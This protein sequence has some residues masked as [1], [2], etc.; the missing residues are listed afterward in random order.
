MHMATNY[1]NALG[2]SVA[3]LHERRRSGTETEITH[4]ID[5]VRDRACL[6]IDDM[7]ARAVRSGWLAG[8]PLRP[9]L[10]R[11]RAADLT[12]TPTRRVSIGSRSHRHV[13][14]TL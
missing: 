7:I 11:P 3:V 6:I 14:C 2:A 4:V 9:A 1:A 8:R 5:D 13:A 10:E 12:G